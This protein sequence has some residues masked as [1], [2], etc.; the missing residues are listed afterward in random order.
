LCI[1]QTCERQIWVLAVCEY[2]ASAFLASLEY[3][4]RF[5]TADKKDSLFPK[6]LQK[7]HF[8]RVFAR[9]TLLSFFL[10]IYAW[11]NFSSPQT[12]VDFSVNWELIYVAALTA[13]TSLYYFECFVHSLRLRITW[14]RRSNG[15]KKSKVIL[16]RRSTNF[17][18]FHEIKSW[19]NALISWS[20]HLLWDGK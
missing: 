16:I 5:R 11:E 17:F 20:P 1:P 18:I 13:N 15:N 8:W 12:K 2:S 4:Q 6:K 10:L 19:N 9:V 7:V 3:A 14:L